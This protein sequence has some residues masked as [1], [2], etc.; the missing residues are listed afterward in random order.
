MKFQKSLIPMLFRR[1]HRSLSA[2]NNFVF[3]IQ[4]FKKKITLQTVWKERAQK[5]GLLLWL[6]LNTAILQRPRKS[7]IIMTLGKPW[8]IDVLT[9]DVHASTSSLLS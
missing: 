8:Q 7:Y 1:N 4:T 9:P 6:E 5:L 2:T 3:K